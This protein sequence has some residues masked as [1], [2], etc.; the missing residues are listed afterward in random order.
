MG[1]GV[2]KI[3]KDQEGSEE[4]Q[5]AAAACTREPFPC[6]VSALF[7]RCDDCAGRR[8]RAVCTTADWRD[9]TARQAA[10]PGEAITYHCT[11]AGKAPHSQGFTP[12]WPSSPPGALLG[13][14]RPAPTSPEA[15]ILTS[16]FIL[17]AD[18]AKNKKISR[19][20]FR[21][22]HLGSRFARGRA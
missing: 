10:A 9:V 21:F 6:H 22:V 20:S 3:G 17:Q 14:S 12:G 15:E 5:R 7:T 8:E 1:R 18:H 11:W 19:R 13:V 16:H 4:E 2:L